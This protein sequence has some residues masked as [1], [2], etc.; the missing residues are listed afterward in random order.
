VVTD[1]AG[2]S[3]TATVATRRVDNTKPT[4][5]LT[6][7]GANLRSTVTLTGTATDAGSGV[8]SVAFERSA[9]GSGG[10]WTAIG[11]DTDGADG[12]SASFDT[13]AAGD[14]LYDLRVVVTDRAGNSET[15]TVATRRVDNTAPTTGHDAP[16]G[17]AASDVTVTLT[18][19]DSGSGASATQHR[20]DGGPWQSGTSVLIPAP[21]DHSND[22]SHTIEFYSTDAAGNV[23]GI[24]SATVVIDTLG[25]AGAP[26]DPGSFLRGVVTLEASPADTSGIVS[27]E[28]QF[29][30]AGMEA[31]A[32]VGTDLVAPY[33]VTWDT[34]TVGN[35]Q[36]DL[37]VRV[38]DGAGNITTTNLPSLPKV[39]DNASPT[40]S[41][42]APAASA[43]VSGTVTVSASASD[44]PVASA[45]SSVEFQVKPS[46]AS[47][48]GSLGTDTSSP[49]TASWDTSA[50]PDGPAE[51][52]VVVT[53]VAGNPAFT[54]AARTVNVDND[55]PTLEF[56]HPSADISGTVTLNA[57]GSGDLASVTFQRSPVGANSWTA[58]A[59]D[60]SAPFQAGFDTTAVSDGQ[61][62]LRAVG[63]DGSGNTGAS[64]TRTLRVDNTAPAGSM[65]QPQNGGT[66]GGPA[67][68]LAASTSDAGSGVGSVTFQQRPD[69]SGS[70]TDISGSTW[71]A[72]SLA[73]GLYEVRAVVRDNAGNEQ[74]TAAVT[75]T[76]DSTAPTVSLANPGASLQGA[77]ALTAS[78]S[79]A[80]ATSVAFGI[81]PAGSGTWTQLGSDATS[82]YS[83]S[84][85]TAGVADGVYDLRAVVA[86]QFGNTNSDVR[87]GIQIDNTPPKVASSTP[88]DG[89]IVSSVA[90]ISVTASEALLAVDDVKLDGAAAGATPS[91]SSFSVD[92]SAL[93]AGPHTLAGTMRDL[94]GRT[95]AFRV[96]FTLMGGGMT[97]VPYVEKNTPRTAATTLTAVDGSAT[98]TMP[99]NAWSAAGSDWLV[100]RIDPVPAAAITGPTSLVVSAIV[101]VT[102]RWALA[103]AQQHDFNAPL[104]ILIANTA[105]DGVLPATL[106]NAA[107]RTIAPIPTGNTLPADWA[108]GFYRDGAG[109][110]ILT[111]HLSKFGL[112]RDIEAPEPPGAG[113]VVAEDGLTLRWYPGRDNSGL[114]R[115]ITLLVNGV[116][117][118]DFDPTQFEV[119]MGPFDA[120]DTRVFSF[121]QQDAAGNWSAESGRLR[122][123]PGLAGKTLAEA[124]TA[125]TE[126]GFSLGAV[127][128]EPSPTALPGTV[129]EPAGVLVASMGSSVDL[130]VAAGA[131]EA[132]ESRLVFGIVGTKK[133][134]WKTGKSIAVRVKTT[135]SAKVTVSLMSPRGER[136][137]TWR[138]SVKAGRT[139]KRLP[140]PRQ[141]RRAGK[142]RL[143]VTATSGGQVV[144]RTIPV[145]IVQS[146]PAGKR[147]RP[148]QRQP[149]EIVL[150]GSSRVREDIALGLDTAAARIIHAEGGDAAFAETGSP[151]RN[152]QIVVVDVDRYGIGLVRDLHVVFPSVK[153]IALSRRPELLLRALK[154]G[155]A[156]AV[157]PSAP[158]PR[159]A[160]VIRG[161][162]GP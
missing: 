80:G 24:Q 157:P 53:D 75:V 52:R 83:F 159:I 138:F 94:A 152:V 141:V 76:V 31:W 34:T 65:S 32:A 11:T 101:D 23:E 45:I 132:A 160:R 8:A 90:T 64:P 103:G 121:I 92:A 54:S 67:I 79:G 21:S 78:V 16:G 7:P 120:D 50:V 63:T 139:I 37:R 142:Y 89:A 19:N 15:A 1:R 100:M 25:A 35:G 71:D 122:S 40:G 130:V 77:A 116:P 133:F 123:V 126:R 131:A 3:E 41:V 137:Y 58:I 93:G 114:I 108:D 117:Y 110:H 113:G 5:G 99:A 59:T 148:P 68:T 36:Y 66:V 111:R 127:R 96:H 118:Q 149:V 124:E 107:W 95:R 88:A 86:D 74:T 73:T 56:T 158:A 60:T 18:P 109:I 135:R 72:T 153:V 81:A 57:S 61:Y 22:G 151:R 143:V 20:V 162:S 102:A 136:V 128:E 85:D 6:D 84:L 144:R 134:S 97:D 47:E 28:F 150:A 62:D 9:A 91:G 29:S 17:P 2:N 49:Y 104:D 30:P 105:G 10:P 55:A 115:R 38:V 42:T 69:G 145:Q 129:I 43:Y 48:F 119:K 106:E 87:T 98:V 154:S 46:G 161:L 12:W 14:G 13:A 82:P 155:A 4:A 125:L 51:L 147:G 70:F 33:S 44:T 146:G 27:V 26:A 39:V 156:A 140:M 112:L